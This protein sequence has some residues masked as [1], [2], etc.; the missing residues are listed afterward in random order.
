MKGN[1]TYNSTIEEV[2][3]VYFSGYNRLLSRYNCN[4]ATACQMQM[5]Y[6]AM[7]GGLTTAQ[8]TITFYKVTPSTLGKLL[9]C[10][11]SLG[12]QKIFPRRSI[13][14]SQCDSASS[15]YVFP[16]SIYSIADNFDV[17]IYTRGYIDEKQLRLMLSTDHTHILIP[18]STRLYEIKFYIGVIYSDTFDCPLTED[19]QPRFVNLNDNINRDYPNMKIINSY[20]WIWPSFRRKL[21]ELKCRYYRNVDGKH[22]R[23]YK[24]KF[25]TM[26]KIDV[27][28]LTLLDNFHIDEDFIARAYMVVG[29]NTP[30]S[31]SS[32]TFTRL[33]GNIPDEVSLVHDYSFF[34]FHYFNLTF[35]INLNTFGLYNLTV[36]LSTGETFT[37]TFNAANSYNTTLKSISVVPLQKIAAN[38]TD[39]VLECTVELQGPGMINWTRQGENIRDVP[40]IS[41]ELDPSSTD[42][43]KIT[44]LIFSPID[45]EDTGIYT[46][47]ARASYRI[48]ES[49]EVLVLPPDS[50]YF[51]PEE[52]DGTGDGGNDR[53]NGPIDPD[54]YVIVGGV[55]GGLLFFIGIV[56]VAGVGMYCFWKHYYIYVYDKRK[57]LICARYKKVPMEGDGTEAAPEDQEYCMD[58][59]EEESIKNEE[60]QKNPIEGDPIKDI[61]SAAIGTAMTDNGK[62]KRKGRAKRNS[63]T[64]ESTKDEEHVENIDSMNETL[65]HQGTTDKKKAKGGTGGMHSELEQ[66]LKARKVDEKSKPST[67]ETRNDVEEKSEEKKDWGKEKDDLEREKERERDDLERAKERGAR[68][69]RSRERRDRE[70]R[71]REDR[72]RERRDRKDRYR[73]RSREDRSRERSRED[74][75]RERS[76]EDRSRE[77]SREDRS[78]ERS[79]EDRYRERRREDRYRERSREDRSRERQSREER[80]RDRRQIKRKKRS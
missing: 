57:I 12:F 71:H 29:S 44:R 33:N 61:V 9:A 25:L 2:S 36:R 26:T 20:T 11:T 28:S 22:T 67:S 27:P 31:M 56:V 4:S 1:M 49:T 47:S 55:V 46:C 51:N 54:V 48:Y 68:E 19:G 7:T 80:S 18:S 35:P 5:E 3:F 59:G 63:N 74:R 50:P 37:E 65:G 64:K 41:I 42:T 75:Y 17:S 62:E 76:R 77:R 72:S 10:K 30:V 70:D 16:P 58:R 66:A 39:V 73:E 32:I 15:T 79:R 38:G 23:F 14:E 13:Y 60:I 69:D 53:S 6:Q 78:R 52:E 8:Y 45:Y 24:T 43:F 40:S 34:E 21:Y